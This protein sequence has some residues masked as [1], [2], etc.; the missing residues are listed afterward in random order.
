MQRILFLLLVVLLSRPRVAAQ[1]SALDS[2][3][4]VYASLTETDTARARVHGELNQARASAAFWMAMKKPDSAVLMARQSMAYAISAGNRE[5]E[6]NAFN[7]LGWIS[8]HRGRYDSAI[9]LLSKAHQIYSSEKSGYNIARVAMNLAEVYTRQSNF[10][11]AIRVLLEAEKIGITEKATTLLTD[12]NRQLGII[13][14]ESGDFPRAVGYMRQALHGFAQQKDLRRYVN[15]AISLAI[16]FNNQKMPDSSLAYLAP[17][18]RTAI[19]LPENDYQVGMVN[20][21]LGQA[22]SA[23]NDEPRA[24]QHYEKALAIFRKIN[25][26][27]DVAY[28][29][30]NI[31]RSWRIQRD[32]KKAEAFLLESNR[33]NDSL[34]LLNYQEEVLNELAGMHGSA[35][36]WKLAHDYLKQAIVV[37]D[38]LNL[39]GNRAEAS[40]LTGKYEADKK[41]QEIILLKQEQELALLRLQKQDGLQLALITGASLIAVIA[42]LVINRNRNIQRARRLIEMEKM[43][44]AIARDLHDDIGSTLTSMN[45]QGKMLARQ[46]APDPVFAEGLRKLNE[47]TREMM[48]HMVDIVWA[49]NPRN[50][51][52]GSV[53]YRINEFAAETLEP[54]EISYSYS[55][56]GNFDSVRLDPQ[57]RKDLYLITKEIINNAAKYSGATAVKLELER[58]DGHVRLQVSDNGKGFAK[59]RSTG[60]GLRNMNDRAASLGGTLDI[61]SEPGMG[62]IITLGFPVT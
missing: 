29:L 56:K 44:N 39:Q 38:S 57:Q 9:F 12:I 20:E 28:E 31:G 46:A 33:L 52:I 11:A 17:A 37:R 42:F 41:E 36:N 53:F 5:C 25:N 4:F 16:L 8:L 13:Y 54:Q 43:R 51:R 18:L 61:N 58:E 35:G 26:Q 22:Y 60:N 62:T 15:T 47:H 48:D 6:A 27:A 23:Y 2:L 30:L 24:L 50:D 34:G 55:E 3:S 21:H 19:S 14:R 1:Q 40:E 59:G 32:L 49:I 45:I 7:A 10:P